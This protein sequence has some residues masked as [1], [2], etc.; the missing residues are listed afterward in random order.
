MLV[1]YFGA[2][3]RVGIDDCLFLGFLW[4]SSMHFFDS[5]H[6]KYWCGASRSGQRRR[7]SA[8]GVSDF[9]VAFG[10]MAFRA[11]L[12]LGKGYGGF[13]RFLGPGLFQPWKLH[14]ILTLKDASSL[15][16]A[17]RLWTADNW[18]T[19]LRLRRLFHY[20]QPLLILNIIKRSK[21]L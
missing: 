16:G 9:E 17:S 21:Y 13:L 5:W 15:L 19:V 10:K 8:Y 11:E 1:I 4:Y 6:L 2:L 18:K 20:T 7:T 14:V 3:I 12:H